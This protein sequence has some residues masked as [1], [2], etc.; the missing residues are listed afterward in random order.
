M[1]RQLSK[2]QGQIERLLSASMENMEMEI[3][4]IIN[5]LISSR[6]LFS[7]KVSHCKCSWCAMDESLWRGVVHLTW[8]EADGFLFVGREG[9]PGVRTVQA[10]FG[11]G[12]GVE[13]GGSAGETR[14]GLQLL[15]YYSAGQRR[16]LQQQEQCERYKPLDVLPGYYSTTSSRTPRYWPAYY[17]V[18]RVL[19]PAACGLRRKNCT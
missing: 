5:Y 11:E 17:S 7:E 1:R 14:P 18:W 13:R 8:R 15:P 2:Q 9:E 16:E 3:I 19:L 4:F 6:F 10:S 12:G